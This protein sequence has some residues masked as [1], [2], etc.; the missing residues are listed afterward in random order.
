MF[1]FLY[2]EDTFRSRRK[3][4][5]L[6]ERHKTIYQSGL[7]FIRLPN[8]QAGPAEF[9]FDSFKESIRTTPMF[10]EKK[11]VVLENIFAG[12]A[13][14]QVFEYLESCKFKDDQGTIIFFEEGKLIDKGNLLK[15]FA[16]KP[17]L[18]QE[19]QPLSGLKLLNW[20]KTEISQRGGKIEE[21]ALK[22][23]VDFIGNNLWLMN[24]EI[25]KILTY[26][27][28]KIIK[29]EDI[30]LLVNGKIDNNIFKTIDALGQ[31][32]KKLAI[33]LI[34]K[35]LNQGDSEIYLLTMIVHQF[36]NLIRI[37]DPALKNLPS[38]A[39][40][41]KTG[42]HPFVLQKSYYQAKNFTLEQLKKIYQNLLNT[43]IAIKTGKIDPRTAL[44]MMI[45]EI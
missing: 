25:N 24:N 6:I 3:L 8:R 41:K 43:E 5:E 30:D 20:V 10:Q 28:N 29:T 1:I 32:N 18:Q 22:K 44:E 36:R 33:A 27:T 16:K 19:F 2:G 4:N 42:I 15:E 13:A 17:N 35:H 31:Q 40:I 45:M 23:L 39:L 21:P 37:K 9:D 26:K 14:G 12:G 11:L 34:Q 7:N 38:N